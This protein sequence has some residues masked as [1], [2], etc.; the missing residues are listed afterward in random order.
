MRDLFPLGKVW[1]TEMAVPAFYAA[2]HLTM[3]LHGHVV[4]QDG[5]LVIVSAGMH[6]DEIC[7]LEIIR[8]LIT[9]VLPHVQRGGVILLP[10]MN[11]Y[12]FMQQSRYLP[13]RRDLNR[14]FP[15]KKSG[16]L[17]SRFAHMLSQDVF[18]EASVILDLH[19][20]TLSRTNFPHIRYTDGDD[21]AKQIATDFAAP[22][23][24]KVSSVQGSLRA[25]A[26]KQGIPTLVYEAGEALHID[27]ASINF[28][29]SGVANVLR[30]MDILP[31]GKAPI[32]EET[33]PENATT[34]F[35][36]TKWI[37]SPEGG[38][39]ISA[40]SIGQHIQKGQHLGHISSPF[41]IR[42]SPVKSPVSGV[43]ISTL[44]CPWVNEGD[45]LFHIAYATERSRDMRLD[46]IET[47][48]V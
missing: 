46:P 12:G 37:R 11:V 28:G 21:K 6:G 14:M 13:D 2:E 25:W 20:A 16:S 17:S 19:S 34:L 44:T 27:E 29:V 26:T 31:G 45:G 18:A 32:T 7:G 3:T 40:V 38:M 4:D 43:V 41:H 8:R 23:T 30:A 22:V 10:M 24:L 9:E 39:L 36:A 35:S 42:K 33:S 48:R 5:P 47:A 15:G 1:M